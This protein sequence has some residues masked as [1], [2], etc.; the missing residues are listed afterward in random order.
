MRV[1]KFFGAFL[2]A[3]IL[4]FGFVFGWNWKAF[5]VFFENRKA[6][7]EGRKWVNKTGSLKG[8]SEYI[9]E[10]PEHASVA[11]MV[12]DH[13]DSTIYFQENSP[14]VMGTTA[15]FFILTAY[16][17][18]FD[19]GNLNPNET[20]E[21]AEISKYQLPGVEE[22]M[23]NEAHNAAQERGW[24]IDGEISY[25]NALNLLAQYGDLALSDYLWWQL[26]NEFWHH[27][28]DTLNLAT[29][30]MPLP[31]SGLYQ[32]ISP[33]LTEMESSEIIAKWT[34]E[35]KQ[36]WRTHVIDLSRSY[37]I[38]S[39]FRSRVQDYMDD[40][41]LGN[42]FMEERDAMTLFPKASAKEMT[43]LLQKMIKDSLINQ[44]VSQTVKDFM[45]WPM[46]LQPRIDQNFNRYGAIYDN[47]M[48]IMNGIDFG[49]SAYTGDTAVQALYMD[50]LPIAFW[51]HASG[52]Q[53][54][55]DFMQRLIYDPAMI[56]QLHKVVEE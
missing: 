36:K 27:L 48:G 22:S 8:L 1:L 46:E 54:H 41:R 39:N 29:T 32:A 6:M 4:L 55:Q 49:T 31:F 9:G 42:T 18:Q 7:M 24:V 21:W 20:I 17:E 38:D 43:S 15:N 35:G 47:R 11:S 28:Q 45:D 52:S 16:A 2:L 44:N 56:D 12:I 37:I 25:K 40:N 14:R 53:M 30:D 50:D 26:D 3:T 5:N 19:S 13:P 34:E 51:F 10:N 23:H 33:G